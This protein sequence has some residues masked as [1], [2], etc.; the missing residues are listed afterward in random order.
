[1]KKIQFFSIILV[2]IGI[3]ALKHIA[4]DH[5]LPNLSELKLQQKYAIKS[6]ASVDHKLFEELQKN[7]GS[8]QEVTEACN[9]N[10]T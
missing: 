2:S 8:P 6:S 7:F 9:G 10:Q 5:P 1:M 3:L 4:Y